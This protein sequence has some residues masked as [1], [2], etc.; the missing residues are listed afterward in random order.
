[1]RKLY[2]DSPY[3]RTFNGMLAE[4][5]RRAIAQHNG[6]PIRVLELGAG[7]GSTTS[8][9]LP[10]FGTQVEYTFTDISPLFL[11]QASEQFSDFRLL[12]TKGVGY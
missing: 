4:L 10:V 1:M 5:I 2:A 8:F 12:R 6:A 11:A 3:A 9:V 7:T